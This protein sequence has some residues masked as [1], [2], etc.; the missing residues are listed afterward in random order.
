MSFR[1]WLNRWFNRFGSD[2]NRPAAPE[3][4]KQG[5]APDKSAAPEAKDVL[6]LFSR[7]GDVKHHAYAL[8]PDDPDSTV[9][10]VYCEGLSDTQQMLNEVVLP[11]LNQFYEIY[12]FKDASLLAKATQ[13]Q[14]EVYRADN[15]EREAE[16]QIFEGRLILYIPALRALGSVDIAAMPARQPDDSHIDISVRGSR[17]CFVEEMATNI[18]LI[19]K[20]IR[21]VS[22]AAETMVIGERTKTKVGLLYVQDIAHPNIIQEVKGQLRNVNIDGIF[23]ATQLEEL[24]S[25]SLT[26]FPLMVYTGRPD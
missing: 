12:G 25:P 14:L 7:C 19:R 17:D 23:S 8:K 1:A 11:A 13:L 24:L 18:A 26:L 21:S 22:L 9:I 2:S 4:A 6:A 20:R 5:P 15:W 10:F 3:S 16:Q